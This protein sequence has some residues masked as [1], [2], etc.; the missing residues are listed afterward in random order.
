MFDIL[1]ASPPAAGPSSDRLIV[2]RQDW[3]DLQDWQDRQDLQSAYFWYPNLSF[4]RYV[5]SIVEALGIILVALG[6]SLAPWAP[7]L[8]AGGHIVR[9][10]VDF[11]RPLGSLLGPLGQ[12]GGAFG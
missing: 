5:S 3:Q 4:G 12:L 8:A 9:F 7:A 10:W 1:R 6:I 2:D 11:G